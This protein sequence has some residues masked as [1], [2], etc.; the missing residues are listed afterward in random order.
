MACL[1][2]LAGISFVHRGYGQAS[3]ALL[4]KLVQKGVLTQDE[5]QDL[6]EESDKDFALAHAVK[7]G[8]P[9]WVNSLRINGDYRARYDQIMM[10]HDQRP[11]NGSLAMPDRHRFRQQLRL[12]FTAVMADR[13][14]V[15]I[16]LTSGDTLS[17]SPYADGTTY[18]STY[19]QNGSKKPVYID[20][21]YAKWTPINDGNWT[22][23]TTVGK[24]EN[25]FTFTDA[26]FDTDYTPE[27]LAEQVS[28]NFSDAQQLK[29]IAGQFI[30]DEESYT[31]RA[32]YLL[33]EQV[34]WD[35]T[36]NPKWSSSLS[37]GF[38][39][40]QQSGLL[41]LNGNLNTNGI[42]SGTQSVPD[43]GAGNGRVA[44]VDPLTLGY[45]G[46][47]APESGFGTVALNA[48]VTYT[49]ES[50][51]FY[52]GPF[53]IRPYFEY[54]ENLDAATD[55]HGIQAGIVFG[56]AGKKGNWEAS[57]RFK[58]EEGNAWYEEL[59][60]SDFGAFYQQNPLAPYP[61]GTPILAPNAGDRFV[62]RNN[63]LGYLQG[64]NVKGHVMKVAYSPYDFL[65]LSA[66]L[67]STTL[68]RPEPLGSSSHVNRLLL[69]AMWRF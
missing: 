36:W 21:G 51:A 47:G 60:D 24:M 13:F 32:P 33:G 20:L 14:E 38:F 55:A 5:A 18:N 59:S 52:N 44:Y 49:K 22:V 50:L 28:Y 37:A 16:R 58:Y 12:G 41:G 30:L 54:L 65:T 29:L 64:T 7:T 4:D 1:A 3:D 56:K 48:S 2:A 57:Y 46:L 9:E 43:V 34:K 61:N 63:R 8:M 17:G 39:S 69:D 66:T 11:P 68:I 23:V 31:S 35:A 6:R 45:I 53:P 27:G 10:P 15:G 62:V 67:Y 40:I 42:A 19:R 26:L 25:P